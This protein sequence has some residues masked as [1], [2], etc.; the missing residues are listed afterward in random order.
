MFATPCDGL[1]ITKGSHSTPRYPAPWVPPM[2]TKFGSTLAGSPIS[3]ATYDPMPGCW[4]VGF[5]M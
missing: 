2:L 4:T 1:S 3:C 5:G